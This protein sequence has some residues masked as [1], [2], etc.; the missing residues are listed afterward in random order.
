MFYI[1]VELKIVSRKLV[2]FW[3]WIIK[4]L[5]ECI[6]LGGI[7]VLVYELLFGQSF[8]LDD[9]AERK[10]HSYKVSLNAVL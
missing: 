3:V 6:G 10:I 9:K 1:V 2:G 7:Y 5:C 4:L 8:P